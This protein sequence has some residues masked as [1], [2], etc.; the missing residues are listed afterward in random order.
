MSCYKKFEIDFIKRTLGI[1]EQYEQCSPLELGEK[2]EITLF[3]NCCVGLIVIPQQVIYDSVPSDRLDNSWDIQNDYIIMFKG[4]RTIKKFV[5][6]IRNSI[7]HG[8]I[9]LTSDNESEITHVEFEDYKYGEK[10]PTFRLRI[11]V[12]AL[13]KFAKK[14]AETMLSKL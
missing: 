3:V 4:E 13:I 12:K 8:H 14:F 9:Q 11:P 6:H 5:R 10:L 2:Y 1:L 7:A